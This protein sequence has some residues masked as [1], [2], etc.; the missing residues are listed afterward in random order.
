MNLHTLYKRYRDEIKHIY[1]IDTHKYIHRSF[2]VKTEEWY[3]LSSVHSF[4]SKT[5]RIKY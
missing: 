5:N 3:R 4:K 1:C 2:S